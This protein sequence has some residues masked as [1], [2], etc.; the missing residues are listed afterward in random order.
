MAFYDNSKYMR[1]YSVINRGRI[2]FQSY[3]HHLRTTIPPLLPTCTASR[4]TD[5]IQLGD[6]VPLVLSR[7]SIAT[8]DFCFSNPWFLEPSDLVRCIKSSDPI[9]P[10]TAQQQFWSGVLYVM[11]QPRDS[12]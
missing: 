4:R 8:N 7:Q 3:P 11:M 5:G 9:Y 1:I 6:N 2:G 10:I 12:R